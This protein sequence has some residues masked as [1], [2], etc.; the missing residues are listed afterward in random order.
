[1]VKYSDRKF[2]LASVSLIT[3]IVGLFFKTITGGEFNAALAI[4]LGAYNVAHV[5]EK[6]D[7]IETTQS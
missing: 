5:K 1:M 2:I 3:I 4:I 6:K 7:A